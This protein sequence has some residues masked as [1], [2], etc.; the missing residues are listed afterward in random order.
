MREK[1]RGRNGHDKTI[2][3]WFRSRP[4][5][6]SRT[7]KLKKFFS[8]DRFFSRRHK[9]IGLLSAV[10]HFNKATSY[11]PPRSRKEI[12]K[13]EIKISHWAIFGTSWRGRRRQQLEKICFME[14]QTNTS[15]SLF[16]FLISKRI[17]Y[18]SNILNLSEKLIINYQKMK[19]KL[20][21]IFMFGI[22]NFHATRKSRAEKLIGRKVDLLST[23]RANQGNNLLLNEL[24]HNC[25]PA[26]TMKI[27]LH[28]VITFI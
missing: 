13:W 8:D 9:I 12:W 24:T 10:L 16:T 7:D 17:I 3:F 18:K 28:V 23:C 15:E 21:W 26:P 27:T 25:E 1:K 5:H 14:K 20:T 2:M 19:I 4:L 22:L 11:F 6:N